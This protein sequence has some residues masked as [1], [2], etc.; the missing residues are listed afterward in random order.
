VV[1][2]KQKDGYLA[3][4][5]RMTFKLEVIKASK[6]R[7]LEGISYTDSEY[8][9]Y[10]LRKVKTIL[11]INITLYHYQLGRDGQTVSELMYQK[12]IHN[13]YRIIDRMLNSFNKEERDLP[14]YKSLICIIKINLKVYY[15]TILTGDFEHNENLN[16]MDDRIRAFDEDLYEYLGSIKKFHIIPIVKLWRKGIKPNSPFFLWIYHV[17]SRCHRIIR[18][19]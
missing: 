17:I 10:P 7:H 15:K 14:Y 9:F 8:C 6:L 12:N 19:Q 1:L 5:H 4:M 16:V 18:K 2:G 3:V 11:F 13:L